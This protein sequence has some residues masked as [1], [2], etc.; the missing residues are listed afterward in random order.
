[1]SQPPGVPLPPSYESRNP[2][3]F[4]KQPFRGAS[5]LPSH[6]SP[7]AQGRFF[8][9]MSHAAL[10]MYDS[11]F[12]LLRNPSGALSLPHLSRNPSGA[13]LLQT[14]ASG[15]PAAC[16]RLCSRQ[17][18]L[19][20]APSLLQL[21]SAWSTLWYLPAWPLRWSRTERWDVLKVNFYRIFSH[22]KLLGLMTFHNSFVIF[23]LIVRENW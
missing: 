10:Q 22:S 18:N 19:T 7:N 8:P 13:P 3:P 1:M 21:W 17:W 6:E 16:C 11:H 9:L 4:V 15:L 14:P 5:L 12:S 20:W 2:F 23:I